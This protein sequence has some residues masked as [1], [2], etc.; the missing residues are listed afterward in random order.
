M[1]QEKLQKLFHFKKANDPQLEDD[2]YLLKANPNFIIQS[3]PYNQLAPYSISFQLNGMFTD[4]GDFSTLEIAME[5]SV[6]I[7]KEICDNFYG[8]NIK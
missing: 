7:F 2:C 4:Y 8:K 3:C 5:K 6:K 1:K